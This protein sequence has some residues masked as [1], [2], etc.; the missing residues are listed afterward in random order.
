MIGGVPLLFQGQIILFYQS[1]T[2]IK[3]VSINLW[4]FAGARSKFSQGTW[5]VF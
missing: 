3:S 5:I 2:I 1:K 4:D